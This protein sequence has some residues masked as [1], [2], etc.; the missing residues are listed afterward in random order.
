VASSTSIV[1]PAPGA[2]HTDGAVDADHGSDDEE[3][4]EDDASTLPDVN[5]SLY[6]GERLFFILRA[7]TSRCCRHDIAPAPHQYVQTIFVGMQPERRVRAARGCRDSRAEIDGDFVGVV[8]EKH[9]PRAPLRGLTSRTAR[10]PQ[11][12]ERRTS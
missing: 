5:R 9:L 1:T 10:A 12:K 6:F 4:I 2:G 11:I 7:T 3:D 8:G